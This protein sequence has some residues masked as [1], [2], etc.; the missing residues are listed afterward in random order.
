M[1]Q[2]AKNPE[3]ASLGAEGNPA[4]KKQIEPPTPSYV[5]RRKRR[6]ALWTLV[7]ATGAGVL[8]MGIIAFLGKNFGTF[9][10]KLTGDEDASLEMGTI[11]KVNEARETATIS[12]PS[13]YLNAEGMTSPSLISA[14]KLPSDSVLDSEI[15]TDNYQDVMTAKKDARKKALDQQSADVEDQGVYFNYTFYVRNVSE[16]NVSYSIKLYATENNHPTNE[17]DE[18]GNYTS[19]SLEKIVRIR[20][21][22][23]IVS[24]SAAYSTHAQTTY[25]YP[26]VTTGTPLPE[27]VSDPNSSDPTLSG[28][29]DIFYDWQSD[30][31]T[32]FNY[33]DRALPGYGIVRYSIVMWFEGY[34]PDTEGIAPPQDGS[35][36]FGIDITGKKSRSLD[37]ATSD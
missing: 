32:V 3:N 33:E 17:K 26:S 21:Y 25:A 23:N 7:G 5:K 36:A 8:T 9:T 13:T 30:L 2:E 18:D 34:D 35:L 37:S 6:I 29:C 22:E 31:F 28:E 20:V 12:S 19:V 16:E 24:A 1:E 15:T 4:P 10:V 27:T 14:D 11:L